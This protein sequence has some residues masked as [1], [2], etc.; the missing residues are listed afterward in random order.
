MKVEHESKLNRTKQMSMIRWMCGV[1]L[2]ER[3]KSEELE[4]TLRIGTSQFDDKE[5]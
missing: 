5:E 3:K 4:R 2:N 1:K